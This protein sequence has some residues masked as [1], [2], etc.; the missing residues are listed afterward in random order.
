MLSLSSNV[1]MK[2]GRRQSCATDRTTLTT[3]DESSRSGGR[4]FTTKANRRPDFHYQSQKDSD[5]DGPCKH[6]LGPS[7]DRPCKHG[8]NVDGRLARRIVGPLCSREGVI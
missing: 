8:M 7:V 3:A 1:G 2:G 4:I 5:V 6:C